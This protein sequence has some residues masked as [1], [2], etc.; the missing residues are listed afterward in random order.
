MEEEEGSKD[1]KQR[2]KKNKQ[3]EEGR[4]REAMVV[5]G[6]EKGKMDGGRIV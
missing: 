4:C 2:W 1:L 5:W 3:R 6:D